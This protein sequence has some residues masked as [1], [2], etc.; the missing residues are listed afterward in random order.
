MPNL[1]SF[2]AEHK[3]KA[4]VAFKTRAELRAW[5]REHFAQKEGVWAAYPR[6]TGD[7][8]SEDAPTPDTIAEECLCVG[9][10]DS[11]P[12][13]LSDDFTLL[14]IAPRKPTSNWSAVNKARVARLI[15]EGLMKQPGLHA[16]DLAKKN[17]KWDALNDVENLVE[18]KEL[19]EALTANSEAQKNWSAFPKSI[20]RGILEWILNA[21]SEEAKSK[22]IQETVEYAALNLRANT[23]GAKKK[24][25][26]LISG[27]NGM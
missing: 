25:E 7:F 2:P 18:P 22:R 9:W 15:E 3:G 26:E 19:E 1:P 5:L 8:Y 23:P 14:Y 21:R 6:K 4:V 27:R 11:L 17:G 10:I 12:N 16:I 13:K 20:K 24:Y